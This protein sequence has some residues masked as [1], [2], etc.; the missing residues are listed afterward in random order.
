MSE[1]RGTQTDVVTEKNIADCLME[2]RS[3]AEFQ[4]LTYRLSRSCTGE[5]VLTVT[6][7]SLVGLLGAPFD[8]I[9]VTVTASAVCYVNVLFTPVEV[10]HLKKEEEE[11]EDDTG[12]NLNLHKFRSVL[13]RLTGRAGYGFCPGFKD[14]DF[15]AGFEYECHGLQVVE[16]PFRR[17]QSPGCRVL[18]QQ[19]RHSSRPLPSQPVLL[20]LCSSCFEVLTAI[21]V[22]FKS[23]GRDLSV[24]AFAKFLLVNS[25]SPPRSAG[26]QH[27][28]SSKDRLA[29][30]DD[31]AYSVI[32]K[33]GKSTLV[34]QGD[35]GGE[36]GDSS[37]AVGEG[38]VVEEEPPGRTHASSKRAAFGK[39][40]M[41]DC[42]VLLDRV[43]PHS[44]PCRVQN[45]ST[46]DVD[47]AV[48]TSSSSSSSS[49]SSS[50]IPLADGAASV[51]T[52]YSPSEP[53]PSSPSNIGRLALV[54]GR[55]RIQPCGESPSPSRPVLSARIKPFRKGMMPQE[56]DVGG[57]G[58][59]GTD[60]HQAER[61]GG[62]TDVVVVAA[63]VGESVNTTEGM[64]V[65]EVVTV[66]APAANTRNLL[67]QDPPSRPSVKEETSPTHETGPPVLTP[68]VVLSPD[69]PQPLLIDEEAEQQQQDAGQPENKRRCLRCPHCMEAF[70]SEAQLQQHSSQHHQGQVPPVSSSSSSTPTPT[71]TPSSQGLP[72]VGAAAVLCES[73][74]DGEQDSPAAAAAPPVVVVGGT[75]PICHAT[76]PSKAELERHLIARHGARLHP[77][78]Y[79]GQKFALKKNLTD[80]LQRHRGARILTC[81]ECGQEFCKKKLFAAHVREHMGNL[82]FFCTICSRMF[83]REKAFEEHVARH[84]ARRGVHAVL[85]GSQRTTQSIMSKAKRCLE[86]KALLNPEPAP[87]EPESAPP[88]VSS[89]PILV[90]TSSAH[91][92]HPPPSS[93]SGVMQ[94][95][96][97]R[98]PSAQSMAS[99]TAAAFQPASVPESLASASSNLHLLSVVSLAQAHYD[100]QER[101][102]AQ[103]TGTQLAPQVTSNPQ[104]GSHSP[105]GERVGEAVCSAGGSPVSAS[106][107]QRRP[108]QVDFLLQQ[109]NGPV[110]SSPSSAAKS[111]L[112]QPSDQQQLTPIPSPTSARKMQPL[113]PV[114]PSCSQESGKVSPP[115]GTGTAPKPSTQSPQTSQSMEV[116]GSR[117]PA[118]SSADKQ[119]G[120]G[121]PALLTDGQ[122]VGECSALRE[123]QEKCD[124]TTA[125]EK[126]AAAPMDKMLHDLE[127]RLRQ[128][129][130]ELKERERAITKKNMLLFQQ[131]LMAHITQQSK[132]PAGSGGVSPAPAPAKGKADKPTPQQALAMFA[133]LNAAA[134]RGAG[135]G[136]TSAPPFRL[137]LSLA[138]KLPGFQGNT[139]AASRIPTTT[140]TEER[141]VLGSRA[142]QA[143]GGSSGGLPLPAP[144]PASA[145]THHASQP[146]GDRNE[147]GVSSHP[148]ASATV[149][150]ASAGS[151]GGGKRPSPNSVPFK[152]PPSPTT[153]PGTAHASLGTPPAAAAAAG[154]RSSDL[155]RKLQ[156]GSVGPSQTPFFL[157]EMMKLES[158]M[159]SSVKTLLPSPQPKAAAPL[160]PVTHRTHLVPASRTAVVKQGGGRMGIGHGSS[161]G[162]IG[163]YNGGGGGH[164]NGSKVRGGGKRGAWSG[165]LVKEKLTSHNTIVPLHE[166]ER[167]MSLTPSHS[168]L[169]HR[170]PSSIS[171]QTAGTAAATRS[172]SASPLAPPPSSSLPCAPPSSS[173][174]TTTP[175]H[176]PSA[177]ASASPAAGPPLPSLS[178]DV[179]VASS[180]SGTTPSST[181]FP[182]QS[183]N[184]PPPPHHSQTPYIPSISDKPKYMGA[185]SDLPSMPPLI[186]ASIVEQNAEPIDLTKGSGGGGKSSGGGGGIALG[187]DVRSGPRKLKLRTTSQNGSSSPSVN[188]RDA[189]PNA[190]SAPQGSPAVESQEGTAKGEREDQGVQATAPGRVLVPEAGPQGG[191]PTA[192]RRAEDPEKSAVG[193]A[194]MLTPQAVR[195]LRPEGLALMRHIL[196]TMVAQQQQSGRRGEVGGAQRS[197]APRLPSPT[198]VL[199]MMP[200]LRAGKVV[201]HML[202]PGH[203]LLTQTPVRPS[204]VPAPSPAGLVVTSASKAVVADMVPVPSCASPVPSPATDGLSVSAAGP[205]GRPHS[206][207]TAV[208]HLNLVRLSPKTSASSH[209]GA[210]LYTQ[211]AVGSAETLST[212]VRRASSGAESRSPRERHQAG[213]E[214]AAEKPGKPIHPLGGFPWH[215]PAP[216]QPSSQPQHHHPPTQPNSNS[217]PDNASRSGKEDKE[218]GRRERP[219]DREMV[220]DQNLWQ[221]QFLAT[222]REKRRQKQEQEQRQQ[223][224]QV[225]QEQSTGGQPALSQAAVPPPSAPKRTRR[226]RGGTGQKQGSSNPNSAS[227]DRVDGCSDTSTSQLPP[228]STTAP[229]PPQQLLFDPSV[230]PQNQAPVAPQTRRA[231]GG[232]AGQGR[233]R[234]RGRKRSPRSAAAPVP[235]APYPAGPGQGGERVVVDTRQQEEG[236][237]LQGFGSDG[238][239]KVEPLEAG[240]RC[241]DCGHM[242][243][244]EADILEHDCDVP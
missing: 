59:G 52:S 136:G 221:Q 130:E 224:Q 161:G 14:S 133:A 117:Q 241:D 42:S 32:S 189:T 157:Q 15:P 76:F 166:V 137:P 225:Q 165:G 103:Q 38:M 67:S 72:D 209:S 145:T 167:L 142:G 90:S 49:T 100:Q 92:L 197:P 123:R 193:Q 163:E 63:A 16:R 8:P 154:L 182:A 127:E 211:S 35:E 232:R 178:G 198:T 84:R 69:S 158:K 175:S 47:L 36:G 40:T 239:I 152:P 139:V 7:D 114:M 33:G 80:H 155:R 121:I 54:D 19:R 107:P 149:S 9:T 131:L 68:E 208:S 194:R 60:L 214:G 99:V 191:L 29:E 134:A 202:P 240:V 65:D 45:D 85:E 81:N 48:T 168:P 156:Q 5:M 55:L 188:Q 73:P 87:P 150:A 125:C 86:E 151:E 177:S 170:S 144:A 6:R 162:G 11:V 50:T 91:P 23:T 25:S 196:P 160:D 243:F 98:S 190:G 216:V 37:E 26:Q 53:L 66:M 88:V 41:R 74:H 242:F 179:P 79:C 159:P 58:G 18:I 195:F 57:G 238:E 143:G 102:S 129:E 128:K 132:T 192:Q 62:T 31:D 176:S 34:E 218:K 237:E 78:R 93:S 111:P 30:E 13:W 206:V 223:Q 43:L 200:L 12:G 44:A 140:V 3:K 207:P 244:N 181:V 210:I 126:A 120:M 171:P 146:V 231:G 235:D 4:D 172:P 185:S 83:S 124:D 110:P 21:F 230:S 183:P 227:A 104:H 226:G 27:P 115:R 236:I 169:L 205:S 180:H 105:G 109:L 138:A 204:S 56:E 20:K 153:L 108:S 135:G 141:G 89:S 184:R 96:E 61:G 148:A 28:S 51:V 173:S 217:Q 75:C 186:P 17:I 119:H 234:G 22:C 82:P 187:S 122:S 174:T 233:G 24:A 220:A 113:P 212:G 77:C 203:P 215:R 201:P 229:P 213:S 228:P 10:L 106:S 164:G 64:S 70:S 39:L 199:Q 1:T 97:C 46:R 222:L 71:L 219:E 94:P 101:P 147:A 118:S 2:L 116:E 112:P 95:S